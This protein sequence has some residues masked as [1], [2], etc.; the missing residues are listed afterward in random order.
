[1][2]KRR[3]ARADMAAM[4]YLRTERRV[5]RV[6]S[7]SDRYEG[8]SRS[9]V[10]LGGVLSTGFQRVGEDSQVRPDLSLG[11]GDWLLGLRQSYA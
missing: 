2:K 10:I 1:V 6:S 5:E 8:R 7:G 3:P 9:L 11:G 4:V